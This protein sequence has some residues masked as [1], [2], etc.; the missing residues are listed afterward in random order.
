MSR[1]IRFLVFLAVVL[2]FVMIGKAF[3]INPATTIM[4]LSLGF[5]VFGL[6]LVW[7]FRNRDKANLNR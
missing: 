1:V 6:F 2:G 4:M 7:V 5:A 3:D